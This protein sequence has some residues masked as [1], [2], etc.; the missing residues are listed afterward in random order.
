M[1]KATLETLAHFGGPQAF[2]SQLHV[3]RPYIPNPEAY[4]TLIK[5]IIDSN[6]LTNDGPMVQRLEEALCKQLDA[7]HCIL[8]SNGTSAMAILLQG[9]GVAGEVILPSF[10]FVSTANCL[11]IAGLAPVFCDIDPHTHLLTPDLVAPLITDRTGAIIPT[12]LWGQACDMSGFDAL[13][14]KSGVPVIYDAA[15]AFAVKQCG[16]T[17]A[18][19]GTANVFSFHA[20]KF[21]HTVEG[22]AITTQDAELASRLRKLRNFG[23]GGYDSVDEIGT[24]AKMSEVHAAMGLANLTSLDSTL[25]RCR[26]VFETY[27]EKLSGIQGLRLLGTRDEL[28]PN[29]QY[30]VLE[31]NAG[32]F[33]LT[34]DDLLE[35]LHAE[36]ILARRY[37]YPGTHRTTA[38]IEKYGGANLPSTDRLCAEVLLLPAGAAISTD[39]V[40]LICSLID[41]IAEHAAEIRSKRQTNEWVA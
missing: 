35:L 36:N 21:F 30:V 41:F 12:H 29:Y 8:C 20:T 32:Q 9:L 11:K 25:A 5:Q 10:T 26:S 4:Q 31:I 39:D 1:T 15:H 16:R 28:A 24:N 7:A 18:N 27:R 34:R 2:R 40:T 6:W 19:Q 33:G 37:F 22:G 38:Y 23:F 14:D 17:L 3:N 13:S